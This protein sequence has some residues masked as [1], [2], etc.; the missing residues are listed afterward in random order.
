M[1]RLLSNLIKSVYFNVNKSD[2]KVINTNKKIE[3]MPEFKSQVR[4]PE[5]FKFV[6]GLNVINVDEIIEEQKKSMSKDV[7]LIIQ[8]AQEEAEQILEEARVEA[9]QIKKDAFKE[10]MDKG[11]SEGSKRA[12]DEADVLEKEYAEKEMQLTMEYEHILS[13]IEPHFAEL[14]TKLVENLTGIVVADNKDV[15]QYIID[16][17]IKNIPKSDHYTLHVS[18]GDSYSVRKVKEELASQFEDG[19]IIDIIEDDNL[20]DNQCLIETSSHIIECS[21]DVQLSNLRQEIKLLSLQQ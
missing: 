9:E 14:V 16:R 15:I 7:S 6:P 5:D 11:Y 20:T 3:E 10:G 2:K 17:N 12:S 8:K 19:T 18:V 1:T 13:E 21:L 4:K